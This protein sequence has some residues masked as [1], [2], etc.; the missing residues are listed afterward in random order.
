MLLDWFWGRSDS[1]NFRGCFAASIFKRGSKMLRHVV[2]IL[3][4]DQSDAQFLL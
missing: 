1:M 4:N 3:V 2:Q